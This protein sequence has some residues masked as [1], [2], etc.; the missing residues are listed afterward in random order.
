MI[1]LISGLRTPLIL[2][3]SV[4]TMIYAVSSCKP[5]EQKSDPHSLYHEGKIYAFGDIIVTAPIQEGKLVLRQKSGVETFDSA[6]EKKEVY[7]LVRELEE[8][9]DETKKNSRVLFVDFHPSDRSRP[10]IYKHHFVTRRSSTQSD[11]IDVWAKLIK[12]APSYPDQS[13]TFTYLGH[14][15]MK[16]GAKKGDFNL[17]QS[18]HRSEIAIGT[19]AHH[20]ILHYASLN[21]RTRAYSKQYCSVIKHL[22][23]GQKYQVPSSFNPAYCQESKPVEDICNSSPAEP[24]CE[25]EIPSRLTKLNSNVTN[26]TIKVENAAPLLAFE[27][28]RYRLI[29]NENSAFLEI[30]KDEESFDIEFCRGLAGHARNSRNYSNSNC[31]L[32]LDEKQTALS[33]SCQFEVTFKDAGSYEEKVC[34][35]IIENTKSPKGEFQVLQFLKR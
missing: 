15:I 23:A 16:E 35:M 10:L 13:K 31:K 22:P 30:Q 20:P 18:I 5:K 6:E 33:K 34:N 32:S 21:I 11:R 3:F 28:T 19:K 24:G 17:F 9:T 2:I 29:G 25:P 7:E 1:H 8:E 12:T 26:W 27:N 14:A 4:F